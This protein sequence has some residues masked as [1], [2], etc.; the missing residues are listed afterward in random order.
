MSGD[1]EVLPGGIDADQRADV[2]DLLGAMIRGA[3][4]SSI[5]PHFAPLS[6]VLTD[7]KLGGDDV[8]PPTRLRFVCLCGLGSC[9]CFFQGCAGCAFVAT[10]RLESLEAALLSLLRA[11]L[12][13]RGGGA[14]TTL[15]D[16]ALLDVSKAGGDEDASQAIARRLHVLFDADDEALKIQQ[17]GNLP[18][19]ARPA[20]SRN[21]P[22][23]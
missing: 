3:K 17:R 13:W 5:L 4:S 16:K 20:P 21:L 2:T 22:I 9:C 8:S 23:C 7:P 10:G 18:L 1:L 14:S 12:A 6:E 11:I 19:Y 15:A